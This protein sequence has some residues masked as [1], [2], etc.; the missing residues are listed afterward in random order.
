MSLNCLFEL[1]NHHYQRYDRP[2]LVAIV[3]FVE[4]IVRK[5]RLQIAVTETF[6]AYQL[7]HGSPIFLRTTAPP[8]STPGAG[9]VISGAGTSSTLSAT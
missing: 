5:I 4:I 2:L 6:D 7:T 3:A 9:N 8:P 1:L